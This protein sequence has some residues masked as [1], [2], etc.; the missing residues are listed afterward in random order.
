MFFSSDLSEAAFP[1]ITNPNI[2]LLEALRD[3][4]VVESASFATTFD[5]ASTAFVQMSGLVFDQIRITT[6]RVSTSDDGISAV[7]NI[8]F[9]QFL[10]LASLLC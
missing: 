10:G 5:N 4:V 1:F 6:S 3:G 8:Q 7:D 2:T 9:S